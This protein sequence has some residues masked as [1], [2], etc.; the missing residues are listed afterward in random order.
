[1]SGRW[2]AKYGRFL[3]VPLDWA[4]CGTE[5]NYTGHLRRGQRPCTACTNAMARARRDRY[6]PQAEAACRRRTRQRV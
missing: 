2:G 5:A 4:K 6:D 3:Q 1:V